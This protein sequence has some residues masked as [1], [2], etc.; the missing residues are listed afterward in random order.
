MIDNSDEVDDQNP[1]LLDDA[2]KFGGEDV[3]KEFGMESNTI[4]QKPIM[5]SKS[6]ETLTAMITMRGETWK[7]SWRYLKILWGV[8]LSSLYFHF[9]YVVYLQIGSRYKMSRYQPPETVCK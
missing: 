6:R 3:P 2:H 5:T 1:I 9:Y 8:E 4:L 7:H